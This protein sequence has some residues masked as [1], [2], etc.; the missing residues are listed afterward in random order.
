V[1]GLAAGAGGAILSP[2]QGTVLK[3]DVVPGQEIAAGH[4]V[5]IVEAMKMENEV[6]AHASGIVESVGV[7]VG[8]GV[9]NGQVIC[10]VTAPEAPA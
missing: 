10:V 6:T 1:A 2:M 4:V 8:Q 7:A 5:C 3:V 9:T